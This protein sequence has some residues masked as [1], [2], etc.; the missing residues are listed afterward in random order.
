MIVTLFIIGALTSLG[1]GF[2][3]VFTPGDWRR[4][5]VWTLGGAVGAILMVLAVLINRGWPA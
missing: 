4:D 3:I 5:L 2:N 1:A